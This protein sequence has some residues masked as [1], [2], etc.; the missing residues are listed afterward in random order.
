MSFL[1]F[2]G[3]MTFLE[4]TSRNML[5][6]TEVTTVW[7]YINSIIITILLLP[8]PFLHASQLLKGKG[9][10]PHLHQL[11]VASNPSDGKHK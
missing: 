5:S 6:A 1:S 10:R 7:R 3:Q 4:P 2:M 9:Y 8:S 11:S